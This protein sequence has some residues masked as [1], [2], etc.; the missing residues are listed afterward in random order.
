MF[1]KEKV[2]SLLQKVAI[3][4]QMHN[5]RGFYSSLFLV[6]KKNGQVRPVINL[7]QFNRWVETLHFKMEGISTL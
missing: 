2:N 5:S 4:P 6:P 7:K 1:L 3:L